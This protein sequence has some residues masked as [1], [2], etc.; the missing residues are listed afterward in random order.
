RGT[1]SV[2][3]LDEFDAIAKRRDDATEVGELKRLVT[4]LLQ[5]IDAWP[6]RGILIAATNHSDL[7]DPAVWR[8]FDRR[9]CFHLPD[10]TRIREYLDS[11]IPS[12]HR[13][14]EM[15]LDVFA[16]SMFGTSFSEIEQTVQ[17]LRRE[18]LLLSRPLQV[19]FESHIRR[20]ASVLARAER[21]GLSLRLIEAGHSQRETHDVTGVSRDTIR[22]ALA[23]KDGRRRTAVR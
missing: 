15:W 13:P 19:Q 2:L 5:E 10:K 9:I 6:S 21:L 12:D 1:A 18:A 3:L 4:V 14:S 17:R 23:A 11:L 8:R 16:A 7:L 22:K 20:H